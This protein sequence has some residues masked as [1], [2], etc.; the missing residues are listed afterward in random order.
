MDDRHQFRANWHDYNGGFYFITICA[1]LRRHFFGQ[2][3]NSNFYP[4]ALGEIINEQIKALPT[5]YHDVE[6]HHHVLMPHHLHFIIKI[7]RQLPI[8]VPHTVGTRFIASAQQRLENNAKNNQH[9]TR[10]TNMGC[11]RPPEHDE[12]VDDFHHNSRLS[13]II[14][15]FKAGVT[16]TARTELHI[17]Q[18]IW[19][20]RYH[21]HIIRDQPTYD[22]I[23][24]YI[25]SNVSN[26]V[27]DSLFS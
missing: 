16:R 10:R 17:N 21:E 6:I 5:H 9:E 7:S 20:S 4:S 27:R 3:S 12:P 2:I 13:M 26:W 8:N 22:K 19:Q 15:S 1:S 24:Q 25:E 18:P 23:A 11:L 14:G